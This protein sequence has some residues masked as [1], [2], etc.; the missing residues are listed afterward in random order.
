VALPFFSS[1]RFLPE[2]KRANDSSCFNAV[3]GLFRLLAQAAILAKT[4]A[5][6]VFILRRAQSEPSGKRI[7]TGQRIVGCGGKR[8]KADLIAAVLERRK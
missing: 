2:L 6:E 3:A 8:G 4:T 7:R 1:D 5:Y